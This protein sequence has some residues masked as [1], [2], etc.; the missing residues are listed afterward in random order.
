MNTRTTAL[1]SI[2][3]LAF[4]IISAAAQEFSASVVITRPAGGTAT[5]PGH[6][7]IANGKVHLELPD[8]RDGYFL[9]DPTAGTA[10]FISQ[11]R[12]VFMDA[13][14]SS[15]LVPIL[16]AVDPDDPCRQWQ[17]VAM[18]V[19]TATPDHSWQCTRQGTELID[20]RE[21]IRYE[22][23]APDAHRYDI[24]IDPEIRFPIRIRVAVD[25]IIDVTNIRQSP[26]PCAS[27]E[28]PAGFGKFD[29]Q[30]LIDRIKQ[31]DVW[32]EPPHPP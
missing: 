2:F 28:I 6:L 29:P 9:V 8:F 25:T 1:A 4:A 32:V 31:S 10:F 30:G 19:G 7:L 26:Q 18:I 15:R 27:F 11:R 12:R 5:E 16:V 22:A 23:I 24:W 13:R 14:Q 3:F 17:T 21:M 20:T